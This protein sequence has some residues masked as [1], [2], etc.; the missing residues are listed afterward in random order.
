VGA[1]VPNLTTITITKALSGAGYVP[2]H[3]DIA[4]L[5]NR[6]L[7]N[8]RM[9]SAVAATVAGMTDWDL[10]RIAKNATLTFVRWSADGD[11][12]LL[13]TTPAGIVIAAAHCTP[14][15]LDWLLAAAAA[16]VRKD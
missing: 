9:V 2:L 14:E 11:C 5:A 4:G 13:A 12:E 1:N 7:R 15:C 10:V 8:K 6:V 3:E 16:D